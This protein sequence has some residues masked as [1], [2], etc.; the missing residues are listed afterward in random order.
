M[1]SEYGEI[2]NRVS[3]TICETD[4]I[5]KNKV[6]GSGFRLA[7]II[8]MV[9]M[10]AV[11]MLIGLA[12]LRQKQGYLKD[13]KAPSFE[14][15]SFDGMTYQLEDFRGEVVVLNFW[16]SWCVGCRDEAPELQATWEKYQDQDVVFIGLVYAD[17]DPNALEF[18]A[19]Y[20]ITYLNAADS[21]SVI[22]DLYDVVALPQTFIIDQNGDMVRL[23]VDRV[24]EAQLSTVIDELLVKDFEMEVFG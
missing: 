17:N 1:N 19:Y 9:S 24:N 5:E 4:T 22:H 18:L 15:T 2:E 7:S 8:L 11:S 16:A 23:F 3:E 12:L 21:G 14:F 20:G 6:P 13:G 10:L